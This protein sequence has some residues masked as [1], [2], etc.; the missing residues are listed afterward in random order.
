MLLWPLAFLVAACVSGVF[1]FG[2]AGFYPSETWKM[3][4]YA[5]GTMFV[6]SFVVAIVRATRLRGADE[7]EDAPRSDRGLPTDET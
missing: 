1:G 5:T 6:A 7:D 3:V 2:L 4:F